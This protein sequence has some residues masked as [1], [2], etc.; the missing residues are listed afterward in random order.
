[1]QIIIHRGTHQIG[2]CATEIR[3]GSTRIL[4]DFGA[5]LPCADGNV[6]PDIL[7]ID[8]INCGKADFDAVFLTHYHSDHI[9]LV[10]SIP[11]SIPIFMGSTAVEIL[12]AFSSRMQDKNKHIPSRIQPLH[13]LKPVT[14]GNMKVMPIPADHS[15][16]DAFMYLVETDGKRVLHTGDFRLHGFR[17]TA[18]SK[19][20]CRYAS[21]IDVLI[22]EGTQL[23]RHSHS[24]MSESQLQK[25]ISNEIMLHKYVF[26]LCASTN[27]DRLASFYNATPRGRYFVCDNYQK[28]IL[29]LTAAKS[30]SQWYQF[31]KALTY[32]KNLELEN[33]GFVMPV[34]ANNNFKKIV[35]Q[36]PDSLLIYSMWEGYL[37]RRSHA[38]LE[39]TA[40]FKKS[41]RIRYLHSSGHASAADTQA[42][43][44]LVNPKIGAIPI[45]TENGTDFEKLKLKCPLLYLNDGETFSF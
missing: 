8:G 31:S 33:R 18:A 10:S 9:G 20:I 26:A 17:G 34:R 39:F 2:G 36:Y 5:E 22:V 30:K 7:K 24:T 16:Y 44:N 43:C 37:D 35:S 12:A 1:M 40:P 3:N 11:K 42:F 28:E 15:A 14:I 19:L 27:I 32:G 29:D 41:G 38:L 21:D 4:I 13:P 25:E 6:P 23:S 45:H